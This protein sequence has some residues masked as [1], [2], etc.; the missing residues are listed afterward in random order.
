MNTKATR[1][2]LH[3]L[4]HAQHTRP[5]LTHGRLNLVRGQRKSIGTFVAQLVGVRV[6]RVPSHVHVIGGAT[7]CSVQRRA[8]GPV[9]VRGARHGADGGCSV[10]CK[11]AVRCVVVGAKVAV[12]AVC[13]TESVSMYVVSQ[14]CNR[15]GLRHRMYCP[16]E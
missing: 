9:R 5:R 8:R 1:P 10:D 7:R 3:S 4:Q 12:V 2:L 16:Y 11:G 15:M 14:R 6:R 13:C